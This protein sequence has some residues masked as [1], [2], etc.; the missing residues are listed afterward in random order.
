MA[1][2]AG[3]HVEDDLGRRGQGRLSEMILALIGGLRRC[4]TLAPTVCLRS[5]GGRA[6][7]S[8]G[9][10]AD[11]PEPGEEHYDPSDHH[12]G[13]E[14]IPCVPATSRIIGTKPPAKPTADAFDAAAAP[15]QSQVSNARRSQA[16]GQH[17]PVNP[18]PGSAAIENAARRPASPTRARDSKVD[19]SV[20]FCSSSSAFVTAATNTPPTGTQSA[21]RHRSPPPTHLPQQHQGDPR[22]RERDQQPTTGTLE[23]F[24]DLGVNHASTV[25]GP[26]VLP[27]PQERA[28]HPAAPRSLRTGRD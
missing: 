3:E 5:V 10:A 18:A 21:R 15:A 7:S 20:P 4:E 25:G 28:G 14:R 23:R 19:D 16:A 24:E 2:R 8:T 27:E 6:E 1:G 22:N 11:E 12:R 9:V 13:D 17:R 26:G